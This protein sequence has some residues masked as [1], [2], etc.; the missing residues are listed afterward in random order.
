[1]PLDISKGGTASA[2]APGAR[3]KLGITD[4]ATMDP[5]AVAIT[6]GTISGVTITGLS[7]PLAIAD[8]G[9]AS[10]TSAAARTSLFG[11]STTTDNAVTRYDGTTG[12]IQNSLV[13][14]DDSGNIVTTG[15]ITGASFTG[16]IDANTLDGHDS[17]YF[18]VA[19][20][21]TPVNKAGDTMTGDL[22][23][24]NTGSANFTINADTDNITETDVPTI[25]L[26][27]DG[28]AVV[29]K[30][31]IDST[32]HSYWQAPFEDKIFFKTSTSIYNEIWH[33]GNFIPATVATSGSYTDLINTP[34][35]SDLLTS[36]KTVDGSGSGLDADLLDGHDT[37]YFQT[38]LGYTPANVAGD[39]FTG[40]VTFQGSSTSFNGPGSGNTG[41]E[42]G[43]HGFSNLAFFDF[44]SG[45]IDVDYD[46][47]ILASGGTGTSGGGTL[48]FTA[49]HLAWSTAPTNGSD[50]TNK[51]YVDAKPLS[52][53]YESAQQTITSAG[54]L[55]LAHGLGS[56]PKLVQTTL[57]CV[58]AEQNFSVGDEIVVF[59]TDQS[60]ASTDRANTFVIDATNISVRFSSAGNCF[61]VANKTTGAAVGLTNAD[62]KLIVRA[63]V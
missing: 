9:T 62:W 4:L 15:T 8:G 25:T 37:T 13:T 20:G 61:V 42:L 28:G 3:L 5:S 56:S 49:A 39:T 47:R 2:T 11:V 16:S 36:I 46:T 19:L 50:L 40:G 59:G 31:G 41:I 6:G 14:I 63:W 17:T 38:A 45:A 55:T 1:M 35:A 29:S 60:S 34:T 26:T 30:F 10:I 22:T 23:I 32:N 58:T 54:S 48:T 27:Q 7:S 24:S 33:G 53:F 51:T 57:K 21:Y 44:H 18:Q 12:A 43:G 52:K